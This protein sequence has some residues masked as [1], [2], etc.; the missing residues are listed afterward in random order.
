MRRYRI[1]VVAM[2]VFV[3]G[4]TGAVGKILVP[5]LLESG[6]EVIALSRTPQKAKELEILGAKIAI[7]DALDREALTA[8]IRRAQPEVSR[9]RLPRTHRRLASVA[10]GARKR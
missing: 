8:A 5:L 1:G 3:A 4:S 10:E 6:H 2:K 9:Y 7:A